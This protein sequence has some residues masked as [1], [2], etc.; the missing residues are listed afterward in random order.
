MISIKKCNRALFISALAV[1]LAAAGAVAAK[2]RISIRMFFNYKGYETGK[3]NIEGLRVSLRVRE[4][5]VNGGKSE[6]CAYFYNDY[7][8]AWEGGYRLTNR[9]DYSTFATVRVGGSSWVSRCEILPVATDYY[10]VLNRYD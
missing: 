7:P 2:D 10:V 6:V 3:Y 5:N 1:S 9:D 4:V 8:N